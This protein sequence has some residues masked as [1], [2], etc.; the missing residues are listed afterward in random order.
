[1]LNDENQDPLTHYNLV[2]TITIPHN[3]DTKMHL[4]QLK[5]VTILHMNIRSVKKNMDEFTTMLQSF[6]TEIEIIV[7]TEAML[8]ADLP[9]YP[10]PNYE[11]CQARGDLTRNEGVLIYFRCQWQV[12]EIV[13]TIADCTSLLIKLRGNGCD[14]SILGIYRTPSIS[15]INPFVDSLE[16]TLKQ[17]KKLLPILVGDINVNINYPNNTSEKSDYYLNT[18]SALGYISC[19]NAYT[20]VTDTSKTI[21][22]HMF[23]PEKL[24]HEEVRGMVVE[25]SV[26]DHYT[27]ILNI[28]TASYKPEKTRTTTTIRKTNYAELNRKLQIEEWA[29]VYAGGDVNQAYESFLNTY[30]SHIE[31]CTEQQLRTSAN[32]KIIKPWVT[33][34]L[35]EE[36]RHRDKLIK[37]AKSSRDEGFKQF[38]KDY[39]KNVKLKIISQKNNYFKQKL[40]E[41]GRDLRKTWNVVN[42]VTNKET[43]KKPISCINHEGREVKITENSSLI[44]K[45]FNEHYLTTGVKLASKI[46][47]DKTAQSAYLN[48]LPRNPN[49]IYLAPC[50]I[51]EMLKNI[52]SLKNTSSTGVDQIGSACLKQTAN[53]IVKPITHVANMMLETGIFPDKLKKAT[54]IPCFKQ[55]DRREINNYRPISLINTLAKVFE[56]VIYERI[57]RFAANYKLLSNRQ[58]GFEK[59]TGTNDAIAEV[60]NEVNKAREK[61]L[62]TLLLFIDLQKCFDTIP[63]RLLIKKM[64]ILGIRG[65][66]GELLKSYITGR[67]QITKINEFSSE[68]G[69]IT[70]GL[71]QGSLMAPLLFKLYINDLLT[72]KLYGKLTAFADDTNNLNSA[73]T[74]E[75]LYREANEDFAQIREWMQWNLL[76]LNV[77]KTT[78]MEIKKNSG[79]HILDN[80][81][82]QILDLNKTNTTK[83]LGITIDDRLVWD[84][85][86]TVLTS[87]IRKTFYKFLQ[88]RQVAKNELLRMAYFALVQSH[89]QYGIIAWG[90]AT[91]NIIEKL[92]VAQK[93]VLK[94][95]LKKPRTFPTQELFQVAKVLTVN[96]LYLKEAVTMTHKNRHKIPSVQH[97]HDTRYIS[98]NPLQ[99]FNTKMTYTQRQAHY[100]GIQ[101]YNT[102]PR[103][104]KEITNVHTFRKIAHRFILSTTT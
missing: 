61:G 45:L 33:A 41:A 54:I 37:Q 31:A 28:P 38:S 11:C 63:H 8:H 22:D 77:Q 4:Q 20:R 91:Q 23:I 99:Q 32:K 73:K 51:N 46:N 59:N 104:T 80:T 97:Q 83:Y 79:N 25:T 1:M 2:N 55:G 68:E 94:I 88:L 16:T 13:H 5:G 3:T 78:F 49:T 72:L 24:Y 57:E 39:A 44:T 30:K 53:H 81:Q 93:R 36:M 65:L 103:E 102:M 76:S 86:I 40:L 21:I 42:R 7:L 101:L 27:E 10:I 50:T 17:H 60:I 47:V 69:A 26:T 35:L 95:M 43:V 56:K 34:A 71:P 98:T 9:I 67:T 75:I 87:K 82:L 64:E 100:K 29:E 14:L 85:H 92:N 90:G 62:F 6:G 70:V 84:E 48:R 89:L 19:I 12:E 66:G 15:D 96:Q 18:L 52:N 58:F 74:R